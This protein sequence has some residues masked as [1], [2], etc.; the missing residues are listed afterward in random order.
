MASNDKVAAAKKKAQEQ[1]RAQQRKA[2]A[3]WAVAGVIVLGLFGALA[4]YIAN[5]SNTT[6]ID[7][8]AGQRESTVASENGGFGFAKTDEMGVGLGEA[9][10]R[11]DVYFDFMCPYCQIFELSQ[12]ETLN[13][14]RAE[15][16]VDVYYHPIVFLDRYS[17]G[18]EY[19]TRSASAAALIA[20]E[21]P[22]QWLEFVKKMFENWPGENTPGL[23]DEQIQQIAKDAG[24]PDDV[25]AQIP[26]H[27]F[28]DWAHVMT[29]K[30]SGEDGIM[31]TPA[32]VVNGKLQDVQNDPSAINWSVEGGL[33]AGLR[34]AAEAAK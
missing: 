4:A 10:V 20:E 25:V 7:T 2:T 3:L 30:A 31:F 33:E 5:Q 9:P 14:L 21:A 27:T 8:E 22:E 6:T 17:Q 11:L 34:A 15:G 16:I 18:T 29:E 24:V 26:D 23:S 28:T 1:V 32:L 13:E 19:S 12:T